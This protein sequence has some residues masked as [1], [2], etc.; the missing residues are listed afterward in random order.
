M[1]VF[2]HPVTSIPY[3]VCCSLHL[4]TWALWITHSPPVH[5][6]QQPTGSPQR[7]NDSRG[8]TRQ[9]SWPSPSLLLN[10]GG[11]ASKRSG[12]AARA[13]A[14]CQPCGCQGRAGEGS[15]MVKRTCIL[16]TDRCNVTLASRFGGKCAAEWMKRGKWASRTVPGQC[17]W[18]LRAQ[19]RGNQPGLH[20]RTLLLQRGWEHCRLG[21]PQADPETWQ[22]GFRFGSQLYQTVQ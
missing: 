4:T 15:V 10:R 7:G 19:C 5:A 3:K 1:R 22:V 21:D 16:Q 18:P 2:P 9:H 13:H 6:W 8:A 14:L 11:L 20:R 17:A 12:R